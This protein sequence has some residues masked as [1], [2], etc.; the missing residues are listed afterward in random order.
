MQLEVSVNF[1]QVRWGE[2]LQDLWLSLFAAD[3]R[4]FRCSP[5]SAQGSWLHAGPAWSVVIYSLIKHGGPEIN[6]QSE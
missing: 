5:G 6:T 3:A 4:G 2:N 1:S